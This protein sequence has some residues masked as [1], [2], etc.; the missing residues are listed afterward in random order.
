[1]TLFCTTVDP[2]LA[3]NPC[4]TVVPLND[5]KLPSQLLRDQVLA[6]RTTLEVARRRHQLDLIVTNGFCMWGR[7][8]I[9]SVHFLH[10]SWLDSPSHP[11]R[12]RRTLDSAYHGLYSAA[13][14][15]FERHAFNRTKHIITVS[16]SA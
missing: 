10:H 16:E 3:A 12:I 14:C 6:L 15:L 2:E 5:W 11:W 9:N 4:V 8:D 1:V 13:N 7:S